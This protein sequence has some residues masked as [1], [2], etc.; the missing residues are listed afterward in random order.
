[1]PLLKP[2]VSPRDIPKALFG[3]NLHFDIAGIV[4]RVADSAIEG[5]FIWTRRNVGIDHV[6]PG[7]DDPQYSREQNVNA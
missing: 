6:L 2:R 4:V 5:E 7:S 1:V 3:D